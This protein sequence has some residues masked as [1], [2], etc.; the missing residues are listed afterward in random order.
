MTLRI[1]SVSKALGVVERMLPAPA[2]ASNPAATDSSS[3]ASIGDEIVGAE[4]PVDVDELDAEAL[5]LG[6][7][8][9]V[10]IDGVLEVADALLG[11]VE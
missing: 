4:R 9:L 10:P 11:P 7:C 6:L 2:V 8:G 3:G 1:S 5:E